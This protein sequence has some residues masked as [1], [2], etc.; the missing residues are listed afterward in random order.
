MELA[1]VPH[2]IGHIVGFPVMECVCVIR[3]FPWLFVLPARLPH[4]HVKGRTA[5]LF[6]SAL[7]ANVY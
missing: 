7:V 1:V 2:Q 4:P 3:L 5:V 6:E